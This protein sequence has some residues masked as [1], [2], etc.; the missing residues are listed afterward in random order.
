[1]IWVS[2]QGSRSKNKEERPGYKNIAETDPLV[3]DDKWTQ[4]MGV[5]EGIIYLIPIA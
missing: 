3:F 2:S 5:E 1:M 4:D